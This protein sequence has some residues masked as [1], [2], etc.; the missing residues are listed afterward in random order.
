[1]IMMRH[2]ALCTR[3]R[4]M[5]NISVLCR[6]LDLLFNLKPQAAAAGGAVHILM[7]NHEAMNMDWD[8]DYVGLGGFDG[9]K[10]RSELHTEATSFLGNVLASV[11]EGWQRGGVPRV[12][13][14][15]AQAFTVGTGFAALY[16]SEMPMVIQ[17]LCRPCL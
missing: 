15:R 14:E 10:S 11:T 4:P 1:M 12:L 3:T 16:L 2:T 8:F 7:G 9:W 6:C 5:Y 17:V 13:K